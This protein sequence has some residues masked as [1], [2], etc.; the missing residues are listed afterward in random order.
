MNLRTQTLSWLLFIIVLSAACRKEVATVPPPPAV[1]AASPSPS[2]QIALRAMPTAV[3][4]G[5]SVAL[6]WETK[7][8]NSV[9][10]EPE[11][12]AVQL[13]GSRLVNPASSITYVATAFGPGGSASASARITVSLPTASARPPVDASRTASANVA[14]LFKQNVQAIYFDYDNSDIRPDQISR[15]TATARWLRERGDV[16]FTIQGHCD[17]RGSEEYNLGLGDRRANRI[18]EFLIQQGVNESRMR[19]VSYGEERPACSEETEGCYQQNR[20]ADFALG[21]GS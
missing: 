16:R 20:R 1:Q 9:R 5:D 3:S 8:A 12:G 14:D 21:A 17:D 6:Q 10:I 15:L 13:Q 4:R 18:K 19:T 11:L 7:N 2:P